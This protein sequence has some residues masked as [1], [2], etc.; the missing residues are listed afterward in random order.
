VKAEGAPTSAGVYFFV[1]AERELLY[2]GKAGNLRVRLAQHAQ[3]GGRLVG[4]YE[5]AA[6]V[7]WEVLAD[8]PAAV[9]R[10]ADLLVALQPAYNAASSVGGWSDVAV[11]GDRLRCG[12]DLDG[13]GYGVFA[14]LGPSS[15]VTEGYV[16]LLRLLW[17]TSSDG[18]YPA[19]LS[20][21][22]PPADLA[23]PSLAD[24]RRRPLHDLLVGTRRRLLD[25]LAAA[26]EADVDPVRRPSLRRDLDAAG[27]FFHHGT[28]RLRDLRRRHGLGT[29][30]V[31][32]EQVR[33]ALLS[34]V[35]HLLGADVHLP[36]APDPKLLGPRSARGLRRTTAPTPDSGGDQATE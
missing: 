17:A 23:I 19:S 16:A 9:R 14:H 13:A 21:R 34:E 2:V 24:D 18:P 27:R 20:R 5:R 28:A 29:G 32:Q 31:T 4:M 6:E 25:D 8:E 1:S 11:D 22:G 36:V 30:H 3:G 35:R 33:D 12:T 26:D 10:E 15:E 7:R